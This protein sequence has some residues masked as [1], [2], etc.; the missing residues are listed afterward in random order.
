MRRSFKIEILVVIFMLLSLSVAFPSNYKPSRTP[1]N[2]RNPEL[3]KARQIRIKNGYIILYNKN[4]K[5]KAKIKL[6]EKAIVI[7]KSE[8]EPD[9]IKEEKIPIQKLKKTTL[10][11][12]ITIIISGNQASKIVVLE[13][14]E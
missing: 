5:K 4:L 11:G 3:I 8:V 13:I 2:S 10:E 1:A 12:N 6:S 14:P 9:S 7:L